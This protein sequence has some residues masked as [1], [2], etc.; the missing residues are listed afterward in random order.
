MTLIDFFQLVDLHKLRHSDACSLPTHPHPPTMSTTLQHSSVHPK[1]THFKTPVCERV[2]YDVSGSTPNSFG[3]SSRKRTEGDTDRDGNYRREDDDDYIHKDLKSRVFVDFGVFLKSVLHVPPDWRTK[4]KPIIE[5]V[6]EDGEFKRYYE[7]YCQKCGVIGSPEKPFYQSLMMTAN[8]ALN[9]V[10]SS[11]VIPRNA[12]YHCVN[13]TGT[14]RGG[15]MG[16]KGLAPDLVVLRDECK[17][18]Q[19]QDLHWA[20]VLHVVE[21]GPYGAAICDGKHMPRLIV[22][23]KPVTSPFYCS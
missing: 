2:L 11:R 19:T 10:S 23:G 18:L 4:W 14:F 21:V 5:A 12:Q 17:H 15:V 9:V 6:K 8:A 16:K 1:R 7:E 20:S 3:S 13:S 22:D